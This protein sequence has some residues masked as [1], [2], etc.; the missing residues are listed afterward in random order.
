MFKKLKNILKKQ[1]ENY[2]P[3]NMIICNGE[4]HKK[5]CDC[6]CHKN[7][8]MLHCIPCC[9]KKTCPI[10]NKELNVKKIK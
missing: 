1:D 8:N 6:E 2:K 9:S 7:N 4:L 3:Y 10:C 5:I